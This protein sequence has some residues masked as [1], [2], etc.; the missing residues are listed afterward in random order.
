MQRSGSEH[1]MAGFGAPNIAP[2]YFAATMLR[3]YT[4]PE[5]RY[6]GF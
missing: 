6:V 2:S 3:T 5:M 4:M 1:V